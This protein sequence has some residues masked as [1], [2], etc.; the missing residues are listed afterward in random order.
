VKT[1]RPVNLNIFTIRLPVPAL[2][3]ILHRVSGILLFLAIPV[4]LWGLQASLASQ[5]DFDAIHEMLAS[6][7]SKFIIWCLLAAF[8]YHFVAGIRHLLMD[9]NVGV[10]LKS[11]RFS[12]ILTLIIVALLVVLAGVWLW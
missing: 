6:N 7:C 8:L 11:G 12:A 2:V 4:I 1:R 3:S 5:Q 10:E 9:M